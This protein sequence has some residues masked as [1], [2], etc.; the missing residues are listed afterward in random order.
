LGEKGFNALEDFL[1]SAGEHY[2]AP[3][4]G[5]ISHAVREGG[6]LLHFTDGIRL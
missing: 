4:K 6:E 1:R 5:A 2:L 3:E